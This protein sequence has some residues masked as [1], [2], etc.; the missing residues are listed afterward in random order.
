MF[1]R[2]PYESMMRGLNEVTAYRKD[3]IVYI[4]MTGEIPM[5]CD[6]VKVVGKYPGNIVHIADP[7]YSRAFY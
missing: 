2:H 5:A 3:G 4:F 1:Y 7:R 6:E